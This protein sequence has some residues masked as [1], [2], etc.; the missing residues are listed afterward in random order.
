[1]GPAEVPVEVPEP[2]GS[3]PLEGPPMGEHPPP[4][5]P[6]NPPS[7]ENDPLEPPSVGANRGAGAPEELVGSPAG[8]VVE[9]VSGT[10]GEPALGER[11]EV[12]DEGGEPVCG[13]EG[14]TW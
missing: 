7:T 2:P 9:P 8:G 6:D 13:A 12:S 14:E 3:D 4:E 5:P 1:M 10:G 11:G